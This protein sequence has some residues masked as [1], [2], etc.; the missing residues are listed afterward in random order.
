MKNINYLFPIKLFI[1]NILMFS[2]PLLT[3]SQFDKYYNEISKLYTPSSYTFNYD[4]LKRDLSDNLHKR[5]SIR[6]EFA[7]NFQDVVN[8]LDL[9]KLNDLIENKIPEYLQDNNASEINSEKVLSTTNMIL[10]I[11]N[12]NYNNGFNVNIDE[13]YKKYLDSILYRLLP[14]EI[15]SDYNIHL[16]VFNYPNIFVYSASTIAIAGEILI[17]TSI[18]NEI[19]ISNESFLAFVIAH[20]ISHN[21]LNEYSKLK[22]KEI[23]DSEVNSNTL[24]FLL[25][26]RAGYSL[27]GYHTYVDSQKKHKHHPIQ[28]NKPTGNYKS[29]IE[30]TNNVLLSLK[31]MKGEEWLVNEII[32]HELER[33]FRIENLLFYT[34]PLHYLINHNIR[35]SFNNFLINPENKFWLASLAE[36]LRKM[37]LLESENTDAKLFNRLSR[38]RYLTQTKNLK[39]P[40]YSRDWIKSV[41]E[42]NSC[43][44]LLELLLEQLDNDKIDIYPTR[45]LFQSCLSNN[46]ISSST[47]TLYPETKIANIITPK[48]STETYLNIVYN[49]D[50]IDFF[51]QIHLPFY[52]YKT[53]PIL[54]TLI[55]YNK[56]EPNAIKHFNI[57]TYNLG[58]I[59]YFNLRN[60]NSK[61]KIESFAYLP[62]IEKAILIEKTLSVNNPD[63]EYIENIIKS[64]NKLLLEYY[65]KIH[66]NK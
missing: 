55:A 21:L 26:Q 53:Y 10:N 58:N 24:A 63:K 19:T 17:N 23:V 16:K 27:N 32:Y 22:E 12:N 64:E 4:S 59:Y 5:L 8:T 61:I 2:F 48:A 31:P 35:L 11:N 66:E 50:S 18:F 43:V 41:F 25:L 46:I 56:S 54:H 52:L 30:K 47:F 65:Y 1:F 9:N 20:E 3:L 34:P 14:E 36:N 51:H 33:L 62:N 39:D 45:F 29:I 57:D 40:K 28:K 38:L 60:I 37:T 6:M 42:S 13:K 49:L 44:D 7:N 15:C